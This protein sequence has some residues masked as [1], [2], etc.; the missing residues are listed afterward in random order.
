[1][2]E[3]C[4]R[5]QC[6]VNEHRDDPPRSWMTDQARWQSVVEANVHDREQRLIDESL[7]GS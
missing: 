7:V 3:A 4:A 5:T 1:M 2:S 6:S